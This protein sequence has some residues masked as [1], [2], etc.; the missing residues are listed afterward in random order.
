[1]NDAGDHAKELFTSGGDRLVLVG[2]V[3]TPIPI[4]L[5]GTEGNFVTTSLTI[6]LPIYALVVDR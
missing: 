2:T 4:S 3:S 5:S 1:M 6:E